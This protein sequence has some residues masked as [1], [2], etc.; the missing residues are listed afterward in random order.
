MIVFNGEMA[1]AQKH[2]Q[3]FN[4][5]DVLHYQFEINLNDTTNNIVGI[6]T[7]E[8]Q[9]KTVLNRFSLDLT[10]LKENGNG[11][12]VKAVFE[13]GKAI[14]FLHEN[15]QLWLNI[16]E[17]KP[18]ETRTY[19][20]EYHGIPDDGLYI[21][22]NKYRDRVFFGDNWPNRA[23]N[24]LPTVD[25][26]SDKATVDF[27]V[28]APS[29]YKVV[30]NGEL[31]EE[32]YENNSIISHW[33]TIAP[34]S[35]KI[36]V[37]GVA[38]F[39]RQ[40]LPEVTNVTLSTWVYPQFEEEGF[41]LYQ[42]AEFPL[43][44]Y[45]KNIAPFPYA[46]LANV[47]STTR[48]GGM[49]N[50]SCIFYMEKTLSKEATEAYIAHE[51][52]HQWFGDAVTEANWH[53]IWLSE[54]FATYFT[55]LYY[56]SKYG[57]E[58]FRNRLKQERDLVLRYAKS[59]NA[60]I[61]DTT[62][63]DYNQLLNPNS[64][65]KG[66]WFLHMLRKKIGDEMFWAAIQ[67]YYHRYKNGNAL[68]EDFQEIVEEITALDLNSFFNQ[69][70]Y[71]SGHPVI[72]SKISYHDNLV[73]VTI[74]QTQLESNFKFP[75]EVQFSFADGSNIIKTFEIDSIKNNFSFKCL[76]EPTQIILDPNTC[77]LFEEVN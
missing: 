48:Y 20:L 40:Y 29:H 35:T 68:T 31:I 4:S 25:H 37:I 24:W 12:M 45:T 9:F 14:P 51:I 30:A 6:S 1:T 3:R 27:I 60:P 41:E 71:Q 67:K 26:P 58:L 17:T 33:H 54:G 73:E 13:N 55:N 74:D 72:K 46:K 34:I 62:V 42:M 56:E 28:D 52:A 16:S 23:H 69:W 66:G 61:I 5:I 10:S 36:M 11:M 15:D 22:K 64:Y 32:K 65:E 21:G 57:D 39:A 44:F 47:Q 2:Y 77:L 43:S 19:K 38:D 63:I 7:I 18:S 50:A 75:L 49:E 8:I 70:L 76:H 59:N 53:H